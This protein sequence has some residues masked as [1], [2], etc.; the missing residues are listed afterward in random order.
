MIYEDRLVELPEIDHCPVCAQRFTAVAPGMDIETDELPQE[1]D[2][3]LCINCGSL[4]IFDANLRQ[5]LPHDGFLDEFDVHTREAIL[6]TQKI[7]RRSITA[8]LPC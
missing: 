4:L 6:D 5:V 2:P 1:G 8:G 7:L 3:S